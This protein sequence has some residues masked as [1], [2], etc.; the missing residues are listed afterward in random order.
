MSRLFQTKAF[1]YTSRVLKPLTVFVTTLTI[2]AMA[3]SR[4]AGPS[5]PSTSTNSTEGRVISSVAVVKA[6]PQEVTVSRGDTV[7]AQ[8]RLNIENGFHVNAN[9]PSFSYLKATELELKP[10]ADISVSFLTYPDP[11]MKKFS[12]AQEPLAVYEGETIIKVRL[13]AAKAAKTGRK[14]LSGTLRVQACDD[15]VCYAPGAMEIS[16]PVD[17]K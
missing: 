12:F 9:P 8:V 15:R 13:E 16:I 1:M 14:N 7:D 4:P 6:Q 10:D 17:V 3:C 11:L 2:A 5:T